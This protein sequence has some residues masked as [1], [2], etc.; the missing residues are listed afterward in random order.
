MAERD[1]KMQDGELISVPVAAS[2]KVEKGKMAAVN[3]NGYAVEASDAAGLKVL[4]RFEETVDNTGGNGALWVRVRRKRSFWWTN[5]P[6]NPITQAQ[7]YGSAIV[8]SDESVCTA[9]GATNDIVAGI[10]LQ[11]DTT[12][13]VLVEHA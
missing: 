3:S 10:V 9:A 2:T 12:L 5:D 1:T 8:K 13:G 11:L 4:G 7:M 6:T